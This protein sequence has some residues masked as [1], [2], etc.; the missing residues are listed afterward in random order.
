MLL[1]K[2]DGSLPMWENATT[3]EPEPVIQTPLFSV[4]YK[5]YLDK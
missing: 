2:G 3:V 4:N 5:K 1:K